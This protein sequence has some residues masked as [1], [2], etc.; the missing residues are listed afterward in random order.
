MSVTTAV[1]AT[2]CTSRLAIT[3]LWRKTQAPGV[4]Y[5]GYVLHGGARQLLAAACGRDEQ[6]AMFRLQPAC[7]ERLEL[8]GSYTSR[9]HQIVNLKVRYEEA[10]AFLS[11]QDGSPKWLFLKY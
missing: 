5:V 8:E 9:H 4:S 3:S 10:A 2:T 6:E 1:S 7:T 11:R